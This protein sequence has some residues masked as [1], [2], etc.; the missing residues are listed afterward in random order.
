MSGD[1]ITRLGTAIAGYWPGW[2]CTEQQIEILW[3]M[4]G[5]FEYE[6]A[7]AAFRQHKA[8][9][10]EDPKMRRPRFRDVRDEVLKQ[11]R[12]ELAADDRWSWGD[13]TE[14]AHLQ[15]S[16]RAQGFQYEDAYIVRQLK[17]REPPST[18]KREAVVKS[19]RDAGC[20]RIDE[21]RRI[22]DE[23]I[24]MYVRI[25]NQQ[26]I[27]VRTGQRKRRELPA[28]E[29][30]DTSDVRAWRAYLDKIAKGTG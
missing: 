16:T 22:Q 29:R 5:D 24:R 3:D 19:M 7:V 26:P 25:R 1:E 30:K 20:K 21:V 2:R 8:T 27:D 13:E 9:D 6:V 28:C 11:Y 4:F 15:E 23:H 18:T 10:P 14:L 17:G 12:G